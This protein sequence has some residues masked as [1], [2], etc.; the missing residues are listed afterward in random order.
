[1]WEQ[2]SEDTAQ[3]DK[4]LDGK[5]VC[6]WSDDNKPGLIPALD[7]IRRFMPIWSAVTKYGDGLVEGSKPFVV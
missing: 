7:E 3:S 6:L 2:E 1:M 5:A 4:G